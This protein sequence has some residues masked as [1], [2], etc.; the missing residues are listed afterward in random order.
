MA[1]IV[2]SDLPAKTSLLDS[3]M[4]VIDDG[5]QSYRVSGAQLREFLKVNFLPIGTVVYSQS[6]LASDNAGRLPLFTGETIASADTLYPDFYA[7]VLSHTELQITA[8]AYEAALS[9]YGEC[10]KYVI[11]TVNK[12]IRLPKLV[13]YLKMANTTDGIT[14]SAD[15]LPNITGSAGSGNVINV[16][17]GSP[18][19]TGALKAGALS[20]ANSVI[21]RNS[22]GG[23]DVYGS[24]DFDASLSNAK[25]G[26]SNEVTPKHTTLY[27]WVCAYNAA[28]P[29]SVAQA[30]EFQNALSGKVDLASGV[31]QTDVDYVIES[32]QSGTSWYKVYKS[33]WCEQGGIYN[34]GS[35]IQ[36]TSVNISLL[37]SF[38][39]TDYTLVATPS[40][41]TVVNTATS[42]MSGT[43]SKQV[44]SFSFTWLGINASDTVQYVDWTARGYIS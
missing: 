9:T 37:K 15:G 11:D 25:Y 8:E 39:N 44:S 12:T 13:N 29:A 21:S 35:S 42:I 27:P 43:H 33:G 22:Q 23:W 14:Q 3:D 40:R 10:P 38:S 2:I 6:N 5:V 19:G 28:I 7:W 36:S 31:S 32:Y 16:P 4:V 41:G 20:F 26:A 18:L 17:T 24:I 30:A 34:H 1:D